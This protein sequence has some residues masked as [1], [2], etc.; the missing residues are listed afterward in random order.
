MKRLQMPSIDP[1]EVYTT[2]VSGVSLTDVAARFTSMT[3]SVQA[4][5]L[6]YTARASA[7]ELYLFPPAEWGNDT[8]FVLG[9]LTKG[10]LTDLYTNQMVKRSQPGRPYY[11]HLM[12]LAPL[13]KCPFCGFGHVST[14]DHHLP[15][16]RYPLFSILPANLVPACSD[17][18]KGKGAGVLYAENQISHPYFED[19]RIETDTWLYAIVNET[20]PATAKFSVVV[21]CHWPTELAN[22]VTNY[23]SALNLTLRFA[24]EASSELASLSDYLEQLRVSQHIGKHLD[25]IAQIERKNRRNSWRAAL[26]EALSGS[27]WYREVGYRQSA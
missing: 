12:L 23:V 26:Y 18:N 19:L 27:I 2:C 1:L 20:S 22:R 9:D 5:A 11:D 13:G 24:I 4:Y 7:N 3:A 14:L 16:A 25:Q 8:Q 17:C 21:P 10:E 6:Q 15:K